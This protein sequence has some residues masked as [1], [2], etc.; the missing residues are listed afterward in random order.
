MS[1]RTPGGPAW[2]TIVL[3][4]DGSEIGIVRDRDEWDLDPGL[5][6]RA[7]GADD[8]LIDSEGAEFRLVLKASRNV[9]EPTGR[10]YRP[11]EMQSIAERHVVGM[12]GKPEWLLAYLADI[13][14]SHKI[15]ATILYLSKLERDDASEES[16]EGD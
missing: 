11:E 12:G 6:G 9:I 13:A 15:R 7:F 14:E 8:R 10:R 4:A 2:P 5:Y 1:K 3:Y 16:E